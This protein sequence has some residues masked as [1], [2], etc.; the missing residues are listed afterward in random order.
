MTA[1]I[2]LRAIENP[3]FTFL[4]VFTF[5]ECSQ[6]D[7]FVERNTQFSAINHYPVFLFFTNFG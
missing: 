1:M 3:G 4:K 5:K 2:E 6:E 7:N